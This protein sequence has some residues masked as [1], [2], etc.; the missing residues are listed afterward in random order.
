MSYIC[1]N[2]LCGTKKKWK[3]EPYKDNIKCII[4]AAKT[5]YNIIT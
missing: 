2:E 5:G 1:Y 4:I 3:N